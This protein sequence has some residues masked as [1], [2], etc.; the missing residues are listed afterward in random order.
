MVEYKVDN[1]GNAHGPG[2]RFVSAGPSKTVKEKPTEKIYSKSVKVDNRGNAHGS[3]GRFVSYKQI[4]TVD[5]PKEKSKEKPRE[6]P[7]Y[8]KTYKRPGNNER[9]PFM[10]GAGNYY[11]IVCE[12]SYKQN[13]VMVKKYITVVQDNI[14]LTRATKKTIR[15]QAGI[16]YDA[17]NVRI[18]PIQTID[19]WM[20][21]RVDP[22]TGRPYDQ[23]E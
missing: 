10:Q 1:R 22:D 23:G 6:R 21:I 8:I 14:K 13:G 7:K 3:N 20:S 19:R 15:E 4:K 12:V 9:S 11:A 2:G 18:K 5:E 16:D 17:H